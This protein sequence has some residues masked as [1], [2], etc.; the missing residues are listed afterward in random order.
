M[1]GGFLI[2]LPGEDRSLP[3][4]LPAFNRM[5]TEKISIR[6]ADI[7]ELDAINRVIE[8]AVMSWKLP[9]RVKRLSLPSYRYDAMD[10]RALE[11]VVALRDLDIVGVAA[12]E[13]ADPKEAPVGGP[14]MLLHGI[15]VDPAHHC[16]GIGRR[17]FREAERA[18]Q[19]HGYEGLLVKAQASADGFFGSLGM[20][21]LD[22]DDPERHYANRF[23]KAACRD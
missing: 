19:A 6:P 17:L 18:V 15:Y 2:K 1:A 14:V 5:Q 7:S 8:T 16:R 3:G 4:F 21:R 10:F 23:W 12:W 13:N 9:E 22:P 11:V 20:H